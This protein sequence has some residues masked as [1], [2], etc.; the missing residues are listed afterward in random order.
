VF[1][2]RPDDPVVERVDDGGRAVAE[3]ELHEHA[4]DVALDRELGDVERLGDSR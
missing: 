3:P 4:A 1:V 2:A